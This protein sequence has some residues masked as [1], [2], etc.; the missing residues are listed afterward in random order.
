MRTP[1]YLE[2]HRGRSAK[3]P[4][5]AVRKNSRRGRRFLLRAQSAA[6]LCPADA[7]QCFDDTPEKPRQLDG[8]K[9]HRDFPP[10]EMA[11]PHPANPTTARRTATIRRH[12][13]SMRGAM[14][15]IAGLVTYYIRRLAAMCLPR[16]AR[17][18]IRAV[19][20]APP[21]TCRAGCARPQPCSRTRTRTSP[22]P[23][24]RRLPGRIWRR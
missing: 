15:P 24:C 22:P 8:I 2:K 11:R 16:P 9:A 19:R 4:P 10:T 20:A 17:R 23:G 5:R 6:R 13:R 21:L 7:E 1:A 14:P 3:R 18:E 12:P